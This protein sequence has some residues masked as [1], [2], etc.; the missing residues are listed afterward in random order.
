MYKIVLTLTIALFLGSCSSYEPLPLVSELDLERYQGTWYEIARLPNRFEK[1]LVGV[2][3]QYT[4]LEN[5]K[6]RVENQGYDKDNPNKISRVVGKAKR[7]NPEEPASLKVS[8]F[9]PFYAPYQ[10][11]ALDDDYQYA[12]VGT[13]SRKYLWVLCREAEIQEYIYKKLMNKAKALGFPTDDMELIGTL[14]Q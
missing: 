8:F 11:I 4:L 6:I 2:T 5:G 12:L 1:N 13:P 14:I 7:P 9:G 10:V 3:A